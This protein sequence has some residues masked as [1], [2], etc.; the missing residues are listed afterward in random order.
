MITIYAAHLYTIEC[1]WLS[2]T[3]REPTSR[4]KKNSK[5]CDINA[6]T[7]EGKQPLRSKIC[8]STMAQRPRT[9]NYFHNMT[10]I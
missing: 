8:D 2:C 10:L 9:A 3:I 6:H 4:I 5:F 1:I 7:D